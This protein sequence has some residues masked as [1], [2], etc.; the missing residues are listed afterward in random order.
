MKN[1]LKIIILLT[2][3]PV[4]WLIGKYADEYINQRYEINTWKR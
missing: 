1:I 3:A 4:L 2:V